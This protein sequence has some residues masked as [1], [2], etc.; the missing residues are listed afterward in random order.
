[1]CI[2]GF[3]IKTRIINFKRCTKTNTMENHEQGYAF[4]FYRAVY[5][6]KCDSQFILKMD[7]C[8]IWE[9]YNLPSKIKP[10]LLK[11]WKINLSL[12]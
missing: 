3:K 8:S 1:V 4:K 10:L 12:F 9:N 2:S 11:R 7:M 6:I 5:K